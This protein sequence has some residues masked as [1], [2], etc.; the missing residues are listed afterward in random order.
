MFVL[1][2]LASYTTLCKCMLDTK[3]E[4]AFIRDIRYSLGYEKVILNELKR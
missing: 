3:I 4:A 2:L 1:I